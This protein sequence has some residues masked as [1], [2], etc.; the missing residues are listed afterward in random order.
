MRFL[1]HAQY[2]RGQ[3][4]QNGNVEQLPLSEVSLAKQTAQIIE[5]DKLGSSHKIHDALCDESART[6]NMTHAENDSGHS[7]HVDD[8]FSAVLKQIDFQRI[9]Q[10][11][12]DARMQ[13]AKIS[14]S[15]VRRRF[16]NLRLSCKLGSSS[17]YGSY[18][19][20]L[21]IRF[22]DGVQ[23]LLKIPANACDDQW[24]EQAARGLTSEVSTMELLYNNTSVP[25]P[26]I[27]GFDSTSANPIKCPY[28]LMERIEGIS[29]FHGWFY[30]KSPAH[31]DKFRERAVAEIAKTMVQLNEFTF[32][33]AGALQC[34]PEGRILGIDP[35]RKVDHFADHALAASGSH[36]KKTVYSQHGPFSDPRNYFLTS[37]DRQDATKLSPMRQGQHKLLYLFINW[38]F[39][40]TPKDPSELGFVLTHPDFNVQNMIMGQ[41]GS[42][43]G[44]IDWDG[45]VAVPR[46]IGCEEYPLWLTSDWDPYWW[47][48]DVEGR[49]KID[50]DDPVM[51]PSELAYYRGLYEQSVEA[52]SREHN[53]KGPSSARANAQIQ[54]GASQRRSRT[55]LS[56][57]AR[58]LYISA[59]EPQSLPH[60]LEM[61]LEKI[62]GLTAG[63]NFTAPA[64]YAG[65]SEDLDD[66]NGSG[67]I[68][69]RLSLTGD[70]PVVQE[71]PIVNIEATPLEILPSSEAGPDRTNTITPAVDAVKDLPSD[72]TE[73]PSP[74]S[75]PALHNRDRCFNT[76]E[77]HVEAAFEWIPANTTKCGFRQGNLSNFTT[78]TE[79]WRANLSTWISMIVLFLISVPMFF[80]LFMDW[81]HSFDMYPIAASFAGLL[82][83]DSRLISNLAA[84]WLGGLSLAWI[85]D[86]GFIDPRMKG[87]VCGIKRQG[88]CPRASTVGLH[89]SNS[90]ADLNCLNSSLTE[91]DQDVPLNSIHEGEAKIPHAASPNKGFLNLPEPHDSDLNQQEDLTLEWSGYIENGSSTGSADTHITEP[92]LGSDSGHADNEL[93]P[94]RRLQGPANKDLYN[95]T[96]EERIERIKKIWEEDP[97]YD[98]GSFIDKDICN[99]LYKDNLDGSRMRRLKIGFQ[100]LLASLDDRFADFDGLTLSD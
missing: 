73:L 83:A 94:E 53:V 85:L 19:V 1:P 44:L 99:A 40:A 45:V 34:T 63:E 96:V 75:G 31:Q 70:L 5:M 86:K 64:V 17:L 38:F 35:Y 22:R 91:H 52:A 97:T 6:N 4:A 74:D 28:I 51:V 12:T 68:D 72:D 14:R 77:K 84:F 81:V 56:C 20:L 59:N 3:D 8:K 67:Q 95:L 71:S 69:Y 13:G 90:I 48:Y 62:T 29:L 50:E 82:F 30:N 37:L 98:F 24:D 15:S 93:E 33:E 80:I 41:D 92:S 10:L 49:C 43:R 46:C 87:S 57:L 65:D 11:A 89:G 79:Q 54:G 88:I 27:H 39:Q 66:E 16:Q 23:W 61:I 32:S 55:K 60:N 78:T 2:R 7:N 36:D 76:A 25:V 100:R 21:P 18:H 42:L 58:S 9:P 26:R 47:N